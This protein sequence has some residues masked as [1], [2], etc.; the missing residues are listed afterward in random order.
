MCGKCTSGKISKAILIAGV[1]SYL[2]ARTFLAFRQPGNVVK[3][4]FGSTQSYLAA[5]KPAN[6]SFPFE[7]AKFWRSFVEPAGSRLL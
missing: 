5:A 4:E 1:S 2:A 3:R 6:E 7:R